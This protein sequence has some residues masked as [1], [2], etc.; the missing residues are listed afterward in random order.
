MWNCKKK[1]NVI[2]QF[3]N[4]ENSGKHGAQVPVILEKDTQIHLNGY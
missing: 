4:N 3:F 2:E 1:W